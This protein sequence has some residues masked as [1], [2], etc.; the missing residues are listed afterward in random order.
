M[1]NNY[2]PERSRYPPNVG[3]GGA[4]LFDPSLV[5]VT[6]MRYRLISAENLVTRD[7]VN[8]TIAGFHSASAAVAVCNGSAVPCY[9]VDCL[10]GETIAQKRG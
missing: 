6:I 8:L 7:F 2:R 3:V 9:V 4:M 1:G 10:T 5:G